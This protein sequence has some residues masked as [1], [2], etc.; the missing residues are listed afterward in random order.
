MFRLLRHKLLFWFIVFISFNLII[1]V[2]SISYFQ[3]RE[4][5]SEVF[6]KIRNTNKLLLEDYQAEMNFFIIETKNRFFFE[7][8]SS[9]Y[10]DHHK[11]L[12]NQIKDN[13]NQ[14]KVEPIIKELALNQDIEAMYS[15]MVLY[16]SIYYTIIDLIK[17]RGY[18]DHGLVGQMR[19]AAHRMEE[20]PGADLVS[21]LTLRRHEKDYLLRNEKIYLRYHY[22]LAQQLQANVQQN[23]SLSRAQ[24]Q[25]FT[26]NLQNYAGLL[27]QV[28]ELDRL[29][30]IRDNT[31]LKASLDRQNTKIS[32]LF[33]EFIYQ[34]NFKKARKYDNLRVI[35]LSLGAGLLVLSLVMSYFIAAGI[36]NPLS[37]LTVY[38][39]KFVRSDFAFTDNEKFH[40]SRDEVGRL[41]DNFFI[42]RDKI[43]EQLRFFKLKVE[44]RTQELARA[45][46]KLIKINEANSRFVPNEFLRYLGR[47]SILDVVLGDNVEQDMT[48][49]F[50]DIRSFTNISEQLT[51]QE[52]FDFIN[53]YLKTTVPLIKEH[54]GFIDKYIGDSVM[55]LFPEAP[56]DALETAIVTQ[57]AIHNFNEVISNRGFEPITVG[58][59]IHTGHLIL[60]TI[61]AEKRMETTVISDAVNIASR[62]EGLTV[63]YGCSVVVSGKLVD[64]LKQPSKYNYR[65]LDAVKV[66]GKQ[67]ANRIYEVLDG[68]DEVTF[69]LKMT[70]RQKFEEAVQLYQ[71][72]Q[73]TDAL[74]LFKEVTL[75]NPSDVAVHIYLERIKRLV[76]EGLPDDWDGTEKLFSK[77]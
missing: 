9:Q 39:N 75:T 1:I 3:Q 22:Q 14:L 48:I 15:N 5:I 74:K 44:E 53:A 51:P 7:F 8:G 35:F 41:T 6:Q 55:A 28:A 77:T 13:L 57:K 61:G 47:D 38:I 30:G 52:N 50:S 32:N 10:I 54:R 40:K 45:N 59:G 56:D 63:K 76:N 24:K 69:D 18:K 11:T 20:S 21:L 73:L 17:Q 2:L 72:Q 49:M 19:E 43:V 4:E 42:M 46:D 26:T 37:H 16:D 68:L 65:L 36:T 33:D 27:K 58:I 62:M 66:K 64:N 71:Q 31:G 23:T 34:A 67:Q 60:G 70:T 12:T 25:T 29:I